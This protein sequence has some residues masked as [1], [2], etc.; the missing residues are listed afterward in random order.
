DEVSCWLSPDGLTIYFL[1]EGVD[2]PVIYRAVRAT[3]QDPFEIP[4]YVCQGRDPALSADQRVMVAIGAG[5]PPAFLLQKWRDR[6]DAAFEPLSAIRELKD[7][8]NVKSPWLSGDG[9]TLVFQ[10]ADKV[11]DY[12]G[13]GTPGTEFVVCRRSSLEKPWSAPERL[14]LRPDP[15][16][17]T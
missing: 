10:R 16:Y 5:G 11:G 17:T 2:K 3:L 1:R 8:S 12:P 14:P 7:Q 9:L 4:E 6:P 15:L 13:R